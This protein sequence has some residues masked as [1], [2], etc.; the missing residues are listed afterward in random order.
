MIK[1]LVFDFGDVF[2]TLNK[3]ATEKELEKL[4][5]INFSKERMEFLQTYEKGLISTNEFLAQLKKW[6][7]K[8]P[9]HELVKAWNS[10]LV[11]FP[12][13]RMDFIQDIVKKKQ[14]T[15]I[16]LS[17]TND[18]HM[19]WV[20]KH[21]SF[22]NTFKSCFDAFYLSHEINYR[23]P[24][25]EIFKFIIKKHQ[26]NPSETLFIDD[27]AE[28]T[29]A[30]QKLGFQTWNINPTKEDVTHLFTRKKEVF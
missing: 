23:K 13:A 24:D 15:L 6:Y 4:G 8:I 7:P 3:E 19:D 14:F 28:N 25:I 17:N 1:T 21:I 11:D 22:F 5:I 27:T 26:L 12:R 16:L 29:N 18:L 9:Q 2:L 10:I 20:S 30:A